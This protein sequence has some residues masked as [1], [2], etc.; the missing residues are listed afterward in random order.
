MTVTIYG[1][2]RAYYRITGWRCLQIN[3]TLIEHRYQSTILSTD[4]TN[5]YMIS[6]E[7]H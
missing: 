7:S 2:Y 1:Y 4:C 6:K 3:F 5:L